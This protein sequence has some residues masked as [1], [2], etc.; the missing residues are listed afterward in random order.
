MSRIGILREI[1]A[2]PRLRHLTGPEVL[3]RIRFPFHYVRRKQLQV[4]GRRIGGLFYATRCANF[5]V[6]QIPFACFQIYLVGGESARRLG[7][8]CQW[9]MEELIRMG[10]GLERLGEYGWL[11]VKA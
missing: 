9:A 2:T 11:L 7:N 1:K 5:K 8:Y 4:A 3:R 6:T 10:L